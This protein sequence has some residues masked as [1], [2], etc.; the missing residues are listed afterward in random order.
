M[1]H[2]YT[3]CLI[4]SGQSQRDITHWIVDYL[5]EALSWAFPWSTYRSVLVQAIE[6]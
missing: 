3:A 5:S 2:G 1:L 6:P 4:S